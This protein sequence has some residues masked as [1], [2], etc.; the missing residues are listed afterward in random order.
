MSD[1]S[2]VEAVINHGPMRSFKENL[3]QRQRHAM[4]DPVDLI[5]HRIEHI[6]HEL[7]YTLLAYSPQAVQSDN[8]K[9]PRERVTLVDEDRVDAVLA[10]PARD[11]GDDGIIVADAGSRF[12]PTVEQRADDALVH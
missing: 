6:S 1:F 3:S 8:L 12:D 5:L 10:G 11:R 7:A 4:L 9:T 2:I